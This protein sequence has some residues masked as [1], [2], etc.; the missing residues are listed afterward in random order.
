MTMP[1]APEKKQV[2]IFASTVDLF[3]L[4]LARE[5]IEVRVK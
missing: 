3:L 1:R 4:F 5:R 2:S